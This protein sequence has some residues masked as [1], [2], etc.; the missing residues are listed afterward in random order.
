MAKSIEFYKNLKTNL[1]SVRSQYVGLWTLISRILGNNEIYNAEMGSSSI[2]E[3]STMDRNAFD[4]M[5][6][7]AVETICDFYSA[8]VFPSDKP[9]SLI[10]S[11]DMDKVSSAD[12][13][14]FQ[15]TS[16]RIVDALY[17]QESGFLEVKDMFYRDWETFGTSAFFVT[18]TGD[19]KHPFVV[20]EFGVDNMAIQDG[21]NS[22]PEYAV[23]TFNWYPQVIVDY[24]GGENGKLYERIPKD[25][26][27]AYVKG[28]WNTKHK[29]YCIIHKN[30][31][32]SPDA[33]MG[34]R[35]AKYEGIWMF[36]SDETIFARNTYF[37]NPL[38][39]ARYTRIRGEVYGRSD[40]SNFIN[41]ISAINGII[42]LAY[43]ACGKMADPAI[44]IYDNAI[45][46]D[47]EIDTSAGAV[48]ALDSTFASGVNPIVPI[49]DIGNIAPITDFLLK[50]LSEELVKAFKLDVI[51]PI[52]QTGGMTATEF[53]NRLAIQS[54]VLSGVLMRHL[55]Q[56]QGFF[57]RII[58]IC[59]R[60]DGF[61]DWEKAPDYVKKAI[62]NGE[63]W[64]DVKFNNAITN[65]INSSMQRDFVNTCNSLIMACQ[66][67]QSIIPDVDMYDSVLKLV[68]D[69]VLE[70]VLP[71]KAE[72]EE[73]KA[74]REQQAQMMQQAQLANV[75][76]QTN[77][78]NAQVQ[79]L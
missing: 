47:T 57:D 11:V 39:V 33:V 7:R 26:K 22:Q 6:R 79:E 4:P 10:P 34:S 77:K 21:N 9:F 35:K 71:T 60:T 42:Y 3:S 52:V 45:A 2:D 13:D 61:I 27:D 64:Y 75:Q 44:G 68:K 36:Q 29:V 59:S 63:A 54:E 18:E 73:R 1:E 78:N 72:H 16:K 24:F 31:D 53:V 56:I 8:L 50:Y 46:Q 20:Q 49:Q 30:T 37:E 66:L 32:Y 55:T 51:I 38:S 5:C 17:S 15:D 76:S 25:I 23:L 41:T 70:N 14:W 62:T 69:S 28:D 40:V 58:G 19:V 67:D 74:V 12:L 43:K 48:I 65:I